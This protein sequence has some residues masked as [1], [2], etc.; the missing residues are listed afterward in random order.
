M[1]GTI[2][3]HGEKAGA[4]DPLPFVSVSLNRTS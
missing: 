1:G 3:V 4:P 2:V